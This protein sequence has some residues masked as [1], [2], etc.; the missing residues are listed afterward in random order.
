MKT[1]AKKLIL[2]HRHAVG[3]TVCMTAL[4]RDIKAVR[5][6][7]VIATETNFPDLWENSPYL[8]PAPH[9]K[10][11]Q[12]WQKLKLDYGKSI[13]KSRI[14]PIHFLRAFHD[15]FTEQTGISVPLRYPKPDLH[16]SAKER[17]TPLPDLPPRYWVLL[18]GGKSDFTT[19]HPA[20]ANVQEAVSILTAMGL[21]IV[22]AGGQGVRPQHW[23]PELSGVIDYLG[24]TPSR[25][26]LIRLIQHADG[27]L[28]TITAAMHIAGA[29][30][31]PCIVW[32]GGR[33]EPWWESYTNAYPE[34][35]GQYLLEPVQTE[36]IYLHTSGLLDCCSWSSPGCWRSKVVTP[37]AKDKACKYPTDVAGQMVAKCQAMIGADKIVAGVL[38]YYYS[39]RL[40]K[41]GLML[42]AI[43]TPTEFNTVEGHR[44][45][46][47]VSLELV[48]D[49]PVTVRTHPSYV[50]AP[51]E[52][53]KPKKKSALPS[54]LI[55]RKEVPITPTQPLIVNAPDAGLRT[56]KHSK[57]GGR[58]TVFI[59]CYGDFPDMHRRC[60]QAVLDTVPAEALDL[61]VIGNVVHADTRTWLNTLVAEKKVTIFYDHLEN[62]KKYPAMHAAFTD[63]AHPITTKWLL[64][65]DD[66]T[67][68][69]KDPTWLQQLAQVI[70]SSSDP[71][72]AM[73]GPSYFYA[74]TAG[75]ITWL[76]SASWYRG[77]PFRDRTGKPA[78]NGRF[79]HFASGSF[80]VMRTDTIQR[81]SIP[82]LR[83]G[84][85]G[86]DWCIG[87]QI[88]Q[89]GL[90]C[91]GFSNRKD[92][93]NWSSVPRRG[94]SEEHPGRL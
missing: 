62:K 50:I 93:V 35:W 84:H 74:L 47:T 33:E 9:K 41:E 29:L 20:V 61:R 4:I 26:D 38:S 86:G 7:L 42:P 89:G 55:P 8:V 83:L 40:S 32:A 81:C 54:K 46:L 71:R 34:A 39:G 70:I 12:G 11:R 82:D 56:F 23:H 17:S 66:D 57:I 59:L 63:P 87:E 90:V 69:N 13:R 1:A 10:D 51:L 31:K 78:P 77:V 19:K 48:T 80:W 43:D 15:N 22:Q 27:V 73:L 75:Q 2:T 67:M 76:R 3:D 28:C 24:R 58:F 92:I 30:D 37:N 65:L 36:H 49:K 16:L 44:A 18:A 85:N 25:R 53:P 14:S 60:V 72:L 88:Y 91:K 5:P 64:W 21:P 94:L 79:V 52:P 45:R 6:D 68:V